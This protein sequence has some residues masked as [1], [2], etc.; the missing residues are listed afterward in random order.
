MPPPPAFTP[1]TAN[2][3][4]SS[5]SSPRCSS[6]SG[7]GRSSGRAAPR[8]GPS[9]SSTSARS[10]DGCTRASR[11]SRGSMASRY[12][13]RRSSPTRPVPRSPLSPSSPPIRVRSSRGSAVSSVVCVIPAV[14]LG[15]FAVWTMLA[16]GTHVHAH[17]EAAGH[18]HG[19]EEVA[20]DGPDAHDAAEVA[21][22]GA[23]AAR[24]R[25]FRGPRPGAAHE[26]TADE[27]ES[28]DGQVHIIDPAAAAAAAEPA[29]LAWPRPWDPTQPIDLSGVAGVTTEQEARATKLV[30][31]H[32]GRSAAVRRPGGRRR[33]G[34]CVDRRRRHRQRALHQGPT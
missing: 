10:P 18:T 14:V 31:G 13:R 29:A 28:S 11:A 20:A 23:A 24:G 8:P 12:A 9:W 7:S 15:M 17:E 27:A 4:R 3:R 34:L 16:A 5:S 25:R 22:D 33:R 1:S 6:G 21:A 32:A 19:T 26:H 30:A 2:S